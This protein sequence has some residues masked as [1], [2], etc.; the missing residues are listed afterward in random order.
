M[1]SRQGYGGGSVMDCVKLA[2]ALEDPASRSAV[3]ARHRCGWVSTA[4]LD[5]AR[6]LVCIPTTMGT[7]S[8]VSPLASFVQRDEKRVL[9]SPALAPDIAVL[10]PDATAGLTRKQVVEGRLEALF[11]VLG[12]VV[13]Q[14]EADPATDALALDIARSLVR[15]ACRARSGSTLDGPIWRHR[16]H[17]LARWSA[18]TQARELHRSPRVFTVKVW[19]LANNLSHHLGVRKMVALDTLVPAVWQAMVTNPAWGSAEKLRRVWA[20]LARETPVTLDPDPTVGLEQLLTWLDVERLTSLDPVHR[21]AV[22]HSC[23][24][25]WGAS[26]PMLAGLDYH[27]VRGLLDRAFGAAVEWS[28]PRF[29]PSRP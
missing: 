6:T 7:A 17:Q 20:E 4:H 13:G 21:D 5:R 11:R 27:A 14:H 18:A 28:P 25:M 15:S 8:E 12:P 9:S 3:E 2:L 10:D 23:I 24:R 19:F 1:A 26:L 22:A 29:D 16:R